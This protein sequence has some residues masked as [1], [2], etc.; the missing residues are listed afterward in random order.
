LR[1]DVGK[2]AKHGAGK[3]YLEGRELLFEGRAYLGT[4]DLAEARRDHNRER[5]VLQQAQATYARLGLPQ[6]RQVDERIETLRA[7][8]EE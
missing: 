5:H 1:P 3:E 4:G 2:R 8:D 7:T 6:A